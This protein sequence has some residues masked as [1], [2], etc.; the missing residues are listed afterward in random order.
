[1]L[2]WISKIEIVNAIAKGRIGAQV[3]R[4]GK[5]RPRYIAEPTCEINPHNCQ[6]WS[7]LKVHQCLSRLIYKN[8]Q[9]KQP[10]CSYDNIVQV[11]R[12]LPTSKYAIYVGAFPQY[13]QNFLFMDRLFIMFSGR[14][15]NGSISRAFLPSVA[16]FLTYL[17]DGELQ[18][19]L[20]GYRIDI[21]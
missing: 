1:M 10:L 12:T 20:L 7:S 4:L 14:I 19:F 18:R 8:N 21:H 13:T 15:T 2:G 5:H 11:A 6:S 16:I 3:I 9:R 17:Y